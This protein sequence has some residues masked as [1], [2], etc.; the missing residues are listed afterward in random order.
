MTGLPAA[1]ERRLAIDLYNG[2]WP[3]LERPSRTADE[4]AALV[5]QAHAS[6]YHWSQVGERVNRARGEWM[7]SRVYA[8]LGRA[9]PALWHARRA[10]E[11][12][13]PAGDWDLA[14][15]YEA[16]A[17]ARAVAGDAAGARD[18]IA[19]ARAVPVADDDD[20]AVVEKDL[21]AVEELLR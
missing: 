5:H 21:R 19:R 14:I 15:A 4:D 12:A 10:V 18:W 3:L 6:L 2:L 11:L 9:E 7:C 20:R 17:R 1:E 8:V 13:E 16:V